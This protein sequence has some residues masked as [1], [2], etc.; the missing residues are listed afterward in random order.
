MTPELSASTLPP[1]LVPLMG[2]AALGS[3]H[4]TPA[5][6]RGR[7][8]EEG[9][10]WIPRRDGDSAKRISFPVQELH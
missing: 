3:T 10:T 2:A 1:P 9:E 6:P 5:R 7:E 8:T 4:R